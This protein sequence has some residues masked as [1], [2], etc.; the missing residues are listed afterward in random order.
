[1]TAV[2]TEKEKKEAFAVKRRLLIVWF[3][4][5]AAFVLAEAAMITINAVDVATNR[6]R[7]FYH[8]FMLISICLSTIFGG[9]SLFFFSIKYRLTRKYCR[10]LSAM[11]EGLK[12]KGRGVFVA[13]DPE[14]SEKDGVFFYKVVLDCPPMKRGDI[15]IREVLMERNHSLP[16]FETGD[17]LSFI[18][19]ANVLMAYEKIGHTDGKLSETRYEKEKRDERDREERE[20]YDEENREEE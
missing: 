14:I 1:M 3:I 12:D 10:M 17:V 7:R 18:T 4:T 15:T 5:L 20:R 2:F 16:P 13:I 11:K 6:D 8:A 9:W 19:H